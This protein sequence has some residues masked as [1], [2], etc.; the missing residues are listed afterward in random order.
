MGLC[1]IW[2]DGIPCVVYAI[3]NADLSKAKPE[4]LEGLRFLANFVG[5]DLGVGYVTEGQHEDPR[6]GA[7]YAFDVDE[8]DHVDIGS[9]G[10]VS[11]EGAPLADEVLQGAR[12]L[13][14]I[15]QL[16]GP[17]GN[18]KSNVYNGPHLKRALKGELW[19]EHQSHLHLSFYCNAEM[20]G[21]I[22]PEFKK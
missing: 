22:C 12:W 8:I 15:R 11:K 13:G 19:R 2:V 3:G 5:H 18:Y 17:N 16:I 21:H 10:H 7:G 14:G 4:A 6:H 9:L 20:K 1:P